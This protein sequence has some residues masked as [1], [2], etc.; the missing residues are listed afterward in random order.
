MPMEMRR[1]VFRD[2][3]V[4]DAIDTL[5]RAEGQRLE[6]EAERGGYSRAG[7]PDPE[8]VVQSFSVTH[9]DPLELTAIIVSPGGR[10]TSRLFPASELMFV[11]I[12]YCRLQRIPVART[13]N[14]SVRR[15]AGGGIALDLVLR[16]W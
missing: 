6:A 12:G 9:D 1:L 15:A 16:N 2:A 13:A 4:K 5:L 14:K 11:L 3:E 8:D 10:T 7:L